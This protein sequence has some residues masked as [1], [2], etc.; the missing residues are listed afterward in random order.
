MIIFQPGLDFRADNV[1]SGEFLATGLACEG[2][3]RLAPQVGEEI[4]D[5]ARLLRDYAED[6]FALPGFWQ[7]D[8]P[9]S[10][11]I[12]MPIVQGVWQA[13]SFERASTSTTADDANDEVFS[14]I[15]PHWQVRAS[16][17][18]AGFS[19]GLLTWSDRITPQPPGPVADNPIEAVPGRSATST[20]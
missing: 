10:E 15:I 17:S 16:P 13:E 11:Q 3:Q 6:I 5:E 1:L 4:G 19:I 18:I 8:G 14:P 9:F 2:R 7:S 20:Y 12:L